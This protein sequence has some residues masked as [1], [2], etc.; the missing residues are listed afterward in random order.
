MK[1]DY[2]CFLNACAIG[3]QPAEGSAKARGCEGSREYEGTKRRSG[4]LFFA[5]AFAFGPCSRPL[6][7]ISQG[8][9]AFVLGLLMP[10]PTGNPSP[11]SSTASTICPPRDRAPI[12]AANEK[13]VCI[14]CHTPHNAVPMQPLWNRNMPVSAYRVYSSSS[15][16]SAPGQ[17]TGSSK[18]CL[19]CHDGTIALGS[20]L[21]RT[22]RHR[23][24]TASPP[25]RRE[26]PIWAPILPAIIRFP[27]PMTPPWPPRTR[28]ADRS[29]H[30]PPQ[31][32]LDSNKQLQCTT[33]HDAHDD[34]LGNFLVM[35]NSNSQLCNSCHIP[36]GRGHHHRPQPMHRLP[37]DA[38][39]AQRRV[40]VEPAYRHRHLHRLPRLTLPAVVGNTRRRTG[41]HRA[42]QRH[43]QPRPARSTAAAALAAPSIAPTSRNQPPQCRHTSLM[44]PAALYRPPQV[45]SIAPAATNPIPSSRGNGIGAQP[46]PPPGQNQRRHRSRSR[47]RHR[48]I[49]VSGLFQ[50]PRHDNYTGLISP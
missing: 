18:L 17:P 38:Q 32:K 40:A 25:C 39:C 37:P 42:D 11:A 47:H 23:C 33:C 26:Q 15:L 29:R 28:R 50:M 36:S 30:L 1:L 22:I 31:V 24:P 8:C 34:T 13:Q 41:R 19:S 9:L 6:H 48:Q 4:M 27:S 3:R 16:V 14:F 44:P 46:L 20:I 5:S 45:W 43:Q 12:K 7:S 35:D 49:R 10:V 21:S 2:H